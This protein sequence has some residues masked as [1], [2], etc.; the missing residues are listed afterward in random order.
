MSDNSFFSDD[1]PTPRVT[2]PIVSDVL[3]EP[4]SKK[5]KGKKT[6]VPRPARKDDKTKLQH[7]SG[8]KKAAIT[9]VSKK[10]RPDEIAET[11]D[12]LAAMLESGDSE[13]RALRTL[14]EQY[15]KY[16]VGRAYGRAA[17][18]MARGETIIAALSDQTDTFPRVVRELIGAAATPRD[19]HRNLRRCAELIVESSDVKAA[20][21]AALFKPLMMLGIVVVFV[22][23]ASSWLLPTVVGVFSS[24]GAKTPEATLIMIGVGG[25]VKW[26]F[27][28]IIALI[29]LWFIYWFGFGRK[30]E[31]VRIWKDTM[32]IRMP[33]L[34]P[35]N[36]MQAAAKFSDVVAVCLGSGIPEVEALEIGA[37]ACGNEALQAHIMDHIGK[38]KLGHAVFA[39]VA[40]TPLLPWNFKN[41]IAISPSPRERINVMKELALV[42]HKKARR[43]L[44]AFADRVGPITEMMVLSVAAVVI[45]AVAIPVT[46][47]APSMMNMVQH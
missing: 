46:T 27:I 1:D 42:F 17:D 38:Q 8:E 13:Q 12:D 37:R 5:R 35:I 2:A 39:N 10:S 15:G 21:R 20:I 18:L 16:N 4:P 9:I 6:T 43:R 29:F 41:R 19:L 47:F 40:D 24:I 26:V 33:M 30:V 23:L 7:G 45:L 25:S 11:L 44:D 31:S 14:A 36:Q 3:D 34:G 22:L 32:A 28:V